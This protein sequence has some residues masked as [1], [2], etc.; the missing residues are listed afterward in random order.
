M[1][2]NPA[3]ATYAAADGEKYVL[4]LALIPAFS[5]E[6]KENVKSPLK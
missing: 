4:T 2:D 1:A 6:E 3:P 5:P